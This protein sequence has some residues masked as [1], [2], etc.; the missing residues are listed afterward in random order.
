MP[1]SERTG[2]NWSRSSRTTAEVG[3]PHP[4]DPGGF[5]PA[6]AVGAGTRTT[7]LALAVV[8]P[9]VTV[10]AEQLREEPP[11]CGHGDVQ[12]S[13]VP[14]ACASAGRSPPAPGPAWTRLTLPNQVGPDK[15]R[16]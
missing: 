4:V 3:N 1:H 13:C 10:R 16:V 9:S 12:Q 5:G 11:T 14:P 6:R 7:V 2:A 15:T 8:D